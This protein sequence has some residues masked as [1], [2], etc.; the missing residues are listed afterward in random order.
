MGLCLRFAMAGV[1]SATHAGLDLT[2]SSSTRLKQQRFSVVVMT[3]ELQASSTTHRDQN[4][5][6]L[7]FSFPL[8]QASAEVAGLFDVLT[9]SLLLS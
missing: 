8:W 5:H 4:F 2:V 9:W 3:L 1:L 6:Y 7:L